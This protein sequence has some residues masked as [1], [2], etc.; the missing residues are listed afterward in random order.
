ME[1]V[2]PKR[3]AA[4]DHEPVAAVGRRDT[5]RGVRDTDAGAFKFEA[6]GRLAFFSLG[7]IFHNFLG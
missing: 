1:P 6:V 5:H 4:G 3:V 7:K 2:A